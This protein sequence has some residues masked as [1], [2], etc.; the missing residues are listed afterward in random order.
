MRRILLLGVCLAATTAGIGAAQAEIAVKINGWVGFLGG[1]FVT[2][3]DTGTLDRDYDFVSG[4]RLQFDIKNVTDGGLEYGARIRFNNADRKNN[5]TVD[6]TYVYVKGGFGTITF[7]DAPYASGDIGYVYAHD[8][9]NSKLGLGA[10][11]GDGLDGKFNLFGGSDVFYA[12][13]PTYGIGG[14]N[15]KDTKIKYTSPSFS[16]FSFAFDFTP[17]AGGNGH[18]GPGGVNDLTN[19]ATTRYENIVTGGLNYANTFD[20]T[21]VRVAGSAST[22]NGVSGNNDF[23]AYSFGGQIGLA[24]GFA[25]SVNWVHFSST[26]RAKKSIDSITGDLSY[27]TGPFVASIGYAYTTAEKGNG[28]K[29]S[30][31]DGTDLQANHSVVL[32]FLYNVAPG[33]NTFTE[34][35][36]ERNEFR[37]G[38]DYEASTLTSGMAL[39]F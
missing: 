18:A 5:V 22:G 11:W 29:S 19:D 16:G 3:T 13:D 20:G 31:T 26:F 30:F 6:R 33:L 37:A 8:T 15:G 24:S 9:L 4:A 32:S 25:A 39:S 28:L 35:S 2:R 36:Y 1:V 23:E 7:G 14:L 34:L 21:S 27:A 17:V 12:F 38:R 10:G